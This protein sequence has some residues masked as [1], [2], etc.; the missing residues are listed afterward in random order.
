M[1]WRQSLAVKSFVVAFLATHVPLLALIALVTL[2]PDWLTPWG[3]FGVT[4]IATLVAT[5]FVLA[6]L[7]RLFQPLRVAAD[8]LLAFMARGEPMRLGA[9]SQDEAG[10][11]VRL[12]VQALAH[13]D[14]GRGPLL[15]AG[16]F[17]VQQSAS[18][19]DNVS[20]TQHLLALVEVDRWDEVE[21]EGSV[22]LMAE[23]QEALQRRLH[24]TLQGAMPVLPWGRGRCL[25]MGPPSRITLRQC[26]LPLATPLHV[27]SRPTRYNVSVVV[28]PS[29]LRRVGL[30]A[31]LQRL[32][33]RMFAL[34]A[35]TGERSLI[36]DA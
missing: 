25:V 19:P 7:W 36:R 15:R 17:V 27:A 12:L 23:L 31:A 24:D 28:E 10:R 30:S 20:M 1:K 14:R 11:L 22:E 2:R 26:L 16:A 4:L 35:G 3:V 6:V 9:G 34:R 32:E 33:H 29:P 18:D 21:A 8:G 5:G 13:I